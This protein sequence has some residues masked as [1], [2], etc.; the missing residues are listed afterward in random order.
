MHACVH[1]PCTRRRQ[2]LEEQLAQEGMGP[3]DMQ[4]VLSELEKRESDYTRLQ[5]SSRP[6][7]HPP[8]IC[9]SASIG[10]H[11]NKSN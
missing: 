6:P 11:W 8:P 9:D 7:L 4:T 1:V 3:Q 5:V 2:A 10:E